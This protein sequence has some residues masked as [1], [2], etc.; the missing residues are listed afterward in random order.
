MRC[1]CRVALGM[2]ALFLPVL[3]ITAGVHIPPG[4][5]APV[6]F[7]RDEIEAAFLSGRSP[8][9]GLA[10]E[11]EVAG[12]GEP[13]SY[14]MVKL[15]AA[16]WRV[17]G[18]DGV[19]A[20]YGGLNLAEAIRFG[21]LPDLR[22]GEHRPFIAQRGLKFNIPLDL[23][24]PSYSDNSDAAQA[25]IPEI[26]SRAFWRE[27]LDD[28]ARHRFNVLT[29]WSLNPFPSIVKVPEYPEV[30][31][32]DVLRGRRELFDENFPHDGRNMFK[33]EFLNGAEVVKRMTIEEKIAFWREV[34]QLAK[35]RGVDIYWFTWNAFLFTEEGKHGLSR[36]QPDGEMLKYFRASVRE[37]VKTYPLLA[38][39]G[40]TAGEHM[41]EKLGALG[42]EEWL[43]KAYGEG[44]CD[45]LKAQPGRKFRMIHRFHMT[46]L[47]QVAAYWKEYPGP[48][49]FSYKY[50]VA[51]MYGMTNPPFIHPLLPELSA[52]RRTWLTVRN[53]DIYSFRW[54]DPQFARD[55]IHAMPGSDKTA[56]FYMG[57]DGYCWGREAMDLAPE[58]PRQLVLKKQW[59]S[60]M[61]WGRLSYDPTLPD[62][63]FKRALACRFPEIRAE[64]LLAGWSAASRIFPEIT[65]FF[66]GNIDL[67]WFP[68][69][70]LSHP[71]H[72]GFY[73]VRHFIEGE[74][75]PESGD[76]TIREW[77]ER[78]LQQQP[79]EGVTPLQVA[80][81][82]RRHAEAALRCVK[83]L[84]PRQ[85][86]NKELRQTLGD[87]EAFACL[88]FYYA[89][90]IEGACE[91]A[92]FDLNS[93]PEHQDAA[94][95]HL[96]TALGHWRKYAAVYTGQYRQPLLYNRVGIVHI[97]KLEEKVAADM[98]IARAWK[99]G[100][101]GKAPA[102]RSGAS[103]FGQ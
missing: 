26:W 88:G 35:D 4:A 75:M 12:K 79:M 97:P 34:M 85:G 20:M 71:R 99:P 91:L 16:H 1:L 44:I 22:T 40:I 43:W 47:E 51:H 54:G 80:A 81:N 5:P 14:R 30:A 59:F 69:A 49:D 21:S 76:L 6:A 96:E 31:L 103:K 78:L 28:M 61:L 95:R 62:A 55:F 83:E 74:G 53:D 72:K 57:P 73:T 13:Q 101:I 29:L 19:G 17:V 36:A 7:A 94:I 15:G 82:L 25:N 10:V 70:C 42:K 92:L 100:A 33:P 50:A 39:M 68:E 87:I 89:E 11:I 65:R 24:T 45:A 23:R 3:T 56:G 93:R 8:A 66:W 63:F 41:E 32:K 102:R 52:Q 46:G 27:F 48:F 9:P 60:F 64:T 2:M 18:A 77:R 90:K 86:A 38:G 84:R 37:T 58:S 98:D 67:K